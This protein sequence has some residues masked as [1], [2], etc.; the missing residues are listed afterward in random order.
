M[1]CHGHQLSSNEQ[2]PFPSRTVLPVTLL[3]PGLSLSVCGACL[4]AGVGAHLV[5]GCLARRAEKS[6]Q[7]AAGA[8][9]RAGGSNARATSCSR[10]GQ[11]FLLGVLRMQRPCWEG[12]WGAGHSL[13][14]LLC[15]SVKGDGSSS[16]GWVGTI[17]H[18]HFAED[19]PREGSLLFSEPS[20]NRGARAPP[21]FC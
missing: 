17:S 16:K 5:P 13:G 10:W 9:S 4:E 14:P 20:E 2:R 8:V 6:A 19:L 21:C 11:L 12:I 18:L 3:G 1:L 15:G 7:A